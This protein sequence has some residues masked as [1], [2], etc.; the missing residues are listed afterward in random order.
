M[1][2]SCKSN[3][4]KFSQLCTLIWKLATITCQIELKNK[5]NRFSQICCTYV[6]T[7]NTC[8]EETL[9]LWA[10][11]S[12]PRFTKQPRR[13]CTFK[14]PRIAY[15]DIGVINNELWHLRQWATSHKD[16]EPPPRSHDFMLPM[17]TI[18]T[19]RNLTLNLHYMYN[20]AITSARWPRK[21]IAWIVL[22]RPISSA[23]IPFRPCS[24]NDQN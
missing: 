22:P 20:V 7:I 11:A 16:I 13:F 6:I 12:L 8:S 18:E 2:F 17:K 9:S 24:K 19:T 21:A 10:T 15:L 1:F 5:K 14:K 4:N 23:R 3:P